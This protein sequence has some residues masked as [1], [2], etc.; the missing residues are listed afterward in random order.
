MRKALVIVSVWLWIMV[1]AVWAWRLDDE[2]RARHD[3]QGYCYVEEGSKQGVYDAVTLE[4]C[5]AISWQARGQWVQGATRHMWTVS[6][7]KRI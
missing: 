2:I 7:E 1:I 5:Q 6:G 4:Q 3:D